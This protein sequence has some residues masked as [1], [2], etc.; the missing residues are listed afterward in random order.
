M[1][2]PIHER[3]HAE[4]TVSR[5]LAVEAPGL[6]EV[7]CKVTARA[8]FVDNFVERENWKSESMYAQACERVAID[9]MQSP[10]N[11]Q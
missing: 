5:I 1:K 8:N 3:E 11:P 9:N 2:R 4:D 6:C 7:L 10:A